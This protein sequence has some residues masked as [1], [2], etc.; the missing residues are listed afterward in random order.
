MA[1][2]G[3]STLGRKAADKLGMQCIDLDHYIAETEGRTIPEIFS[4]DGEIGFRAIEYERLAEVL[5]TPTP[6]V[7]ATGG[8]VVVAAVNRVLIKDQFCVWLDAPLAVLVKR[9]THSRSPRPLLSGDVAATT[10]KL[11]AERRGWY[12]E[13]ATVRLEAGHLSVTQM[14]QQIVEEYQCRLSK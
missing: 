12:Q 10:R 8:G 14:A 4:T 6:T 9:L 11:L 5:A 13:V 1:G 7:V 2:V 3:K